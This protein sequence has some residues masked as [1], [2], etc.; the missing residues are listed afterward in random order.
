M[1][2]EW[3]IYKLAKRKEKKRRDLDQVKCIQN[4]NGKELATDK[5]IK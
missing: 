5:D 1:H 3:Q 4:E 2:R